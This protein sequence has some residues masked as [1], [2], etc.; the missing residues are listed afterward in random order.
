MSKLYNDLKSNIDR[1]NNYFNTM[2]KKIIGRVMSDVWFQ[3]TDQTW[4]LSTYVVPLMPGWFTGQVQ[5]P[6]TGYAV[7][8]IGFPYQVICKYGSSNIKN[9]TMFEDEFPS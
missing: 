9:L 2:E 4:P 6:S 1:L 7:K 5:S 3:P 8:K